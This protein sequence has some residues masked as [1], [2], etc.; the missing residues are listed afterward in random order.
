MKE[1]KPENC[2]HNAIE[3]QDAQDKL[4]ITFRTSVKPR[5]I[6]RYVVIIC[7]CLLCTGVIAI[8][9][10]G[11][12]RWRL[13]S[14]ISRESSPLTSRKL[15]WRSFGQTEHRYNK[16]SLSHT[17]VIDAPCV[18][19]LPNEIHRRVMLPFIQFTEINLWGDES[20]PIED[21]QV[22]AAIIAPGMERLSLSN[23]KIDDGSVRKIV[24]DSKI[25]ALK[26]HKCH[27]SLSELFKSSPDSHLH[28]LAL[29]ECLELKIDAEVTAG[30]PTGLRKLTILGDLDASDGAIAASMCNLNELESI[31]LA[32]ASCGPE[33]LAVIC[34]LP[35][36][37]LIH[38]LGCEIKDDQY[39]LLLDCR[40]VE[41]I[42]LLTDD[43]DLNTLSRLVFIPTL[44]RLGVPRRRISE[45][46]L[47]ELMNLRPAIKIE[48]VGLDSD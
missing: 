5:L 22:Q 48:R 20:S 14:S 44:K 15:K 30:F 37:R 39:R 7:L 40:S 32:S 19:I 4:N 13:L 18:D 35:K 16:W 25:R 21:S 17:I 12:H 23:V 6:V 34:K 42:G 28:E 31:V 27:L 3:S 11:L 41:E 2:G 24:T 8:F 47:A 9:R 36:L 26:L 45:A 1:I 46:G 10:M 29:V 43:V 38:L 33:V